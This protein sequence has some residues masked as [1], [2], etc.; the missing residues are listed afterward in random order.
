MHLNA[1]GR[2]QRT[3][4][5]R[6]GKWL[7]LWSVVHL[8]SGV[9]MGLI[10]SFFH[11]PIVPSLIIGF[12]LLV[13]YEMWEAIAQIEETPQNR[14]TDV[15]VGMISFVPTF[16]YFVPQFTASQVVLV[17]LPVLTVNIILAIVGW[18]ASRKAVVLEA[19]LKADI[20]RQK[21]KF[22]ARRDRFLRNRALRRMRRFERSL[23]SGT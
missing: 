5:W 7:D 11:F 3:D 23:R 16:L 6:E 18:L 22:M 1:E 4:I 2:F 12:L 20:E 19:S 8:L 13:I 9:S 21:Q 10:G 15:V 14:V 17:L